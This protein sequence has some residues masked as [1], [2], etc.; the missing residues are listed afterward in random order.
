MIQRNLIDWAKHYNLQ[1]RDIVFYGPS[2]SESVFAITQI[3]ST[4]DESGA[5]R[6]VSKVKG[7]DLVNGSYSPP[8]VE[9]N[10]SQEWQVERHDD[11]KG[12]LK[13][14]HRGKYASVL[15]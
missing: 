7:K 12:R 1:P 10:L 5:I 15:N 9:L 3:E 13:L 11:E 4:K 14:L 8:E 2:G 6:T